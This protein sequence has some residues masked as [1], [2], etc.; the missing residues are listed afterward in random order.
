MSTA[1]IGGNLGKDAEKKSTPN[2]DV[3][4]FS[5]AVNEQWEDKDGA[6]HKNTDWFQIQVWGPLV[7]FAATLKAG[8]P[9]IVEGKIKPETYTADGV[10]HKTFSIKANYIRK[11]NYSKPEED[12]AGTAAKSAKKRK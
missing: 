4:N 2:G 12:G 10:E 5:I 3:V 11:I 6:E 1:R 9:V 8:T 7:K